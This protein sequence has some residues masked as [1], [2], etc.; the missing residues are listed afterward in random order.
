MKIGFNLKFFRE[1]FHIPKNVKISWCILEEI[2][3]DS[4]TRRLG[5]MLEGTNKVIDVARKQFVQIMLWAPV[6][7]Q[8]EPAEKSVGRDEIYFYS[9]CD[10]DVFLSVPK[11][12]V[13]DIYFR[14]VY[15]E[16]LIAS[17]LI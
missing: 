14:C 5:V 8:A 11:S 16:Q 15:S 3:N 1:Y 4:S 7:Y 12:Y 13:E 17:P 9:L 2:S 6:F 10:P